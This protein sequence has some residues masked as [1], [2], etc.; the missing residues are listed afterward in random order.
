MPSITSCQCNGAWTKTLKGFF[1][2]FLV[3]ASIQ[4]FGLFLYT[5]IEEGYPLTDCLF[6][7]EKVNSLAN[8]KTIPKPKTALYIGLD[9]IL[10]G[11][12]TPKAFETY[13]N[14]IEKYFSA[15]ISK[16]S[17]Q[18][19]VTLR[20]FCSK[21]YMFSAIT[22]TTVGYGNVVPKTVAGKYLLFPYCLVGIPAMLF[23]LAYIGKMLADISSFFVTKTSC[24]ATN[25]NSV[26]YKELKSFIVTF[27]ILWAWILIEAAFLHLQKDGSSLSF[28]DGVYF[29]FVSFTTIGYGDITSP[30]TQPLFE[31]RLY[32]GL[33][34]MSATVN[35]FQE[36][37]Q[38]KISNQSASQQ[39]KKKL[40]CCCPKHSAV[41]TAEDKKNEE[42]IVVKGI[43]KQDTNHRELFTYK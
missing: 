11:S 27:V 32:V 9:A 31:F 7:K 4:I 1:K 2:R 10:N 42:R 5:Y 16:P 33:S 40:C 20:E 24:T 39:R 8:P 18:R 28:V 19:N 13:D 38:K 6:N 34:L 21:W 26:K 17:I 41:G 37:Y 22:L 12:L 29:F 15:Q 25:T 35:S 3:V 30:T 23:F 14:E 43:E 36:F